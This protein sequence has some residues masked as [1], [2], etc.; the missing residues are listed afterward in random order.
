MTHDPAASDITD[1][2]WA[3][4]APLIPPAKPG[5]R[6]RDVDLRATLNA[7]LYKEQWSCSWRGL[8]LGS[9]PWQ[10]VY[11]YVRAWRR[12]GTWARLLAA[13]RASS[14]GTARLSAATRGASAVVTRSDGN[15]DEACL[16]AV[17]VTGDGR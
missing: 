9:P 8:P 3:V 16:I 4:L 1:A 11:T 13:R 17:A 14:L 2:E 10:T 12:D 6:R 5:G 7:A 15:R